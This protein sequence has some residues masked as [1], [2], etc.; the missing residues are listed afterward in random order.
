MGAKSIAACTN[1]AG[2]GFFG[3][4]AIFFVGL[5]GA[6]NGATVTTEAE[7]ALTC[8]TAATLSKLSC[9][10]KTNSRSDNTVVTSRKNA[11]GGN[12]T[13]TI[14]GATTGWVQD[15]T[16][17]DAL[18]AGDTF[19]VKVLMGAGSGNCI[20]DAFIAELDSS[21]NV[22]H[23]YFGIQRSSG[24]A[25]TASAASTTST[26]CAQGSAQSNTASGREKADLPATGTISNLQAYATANPR[27][28]ATTVQVNKA[29]AAGNNTVSVTASTT[30][31]FEDTTHSDAFTAGNALGFAVITGAG[32]GNLTFGRI[33]VMF[34]SADLTY[35]LFV[36][37]TGSVTKSSSGAYSIY[38]TGEMAI[39]NTNTEADAQMLAVH[40]MTW[41]NMQI[42]VGTVTTATFVVKSRVNGADGN[43]ALSLIAT[44]SGL[45]EDTTHS[46]ALVSGD[47]YNMRFDANTSVATLI[48][49][50][51]RMAG[52]AVQTAV[53]GGKSFFTG[54]AA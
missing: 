41:S 13:I 42:R 34:T 39:T 6:M 5:Y 22:A 37:E 9:Y 16:N 27:S 19:D 15:L 32:T 40:A 47:K 20:I 10:I 8:R 30:G 3:G 44:S 11:A 50:G 4:G 36:G 48:F 49:W 29:G 1:L 23:T 43:Q 14:A 2:G 24:A 51:S 53:E 33:S 52:P 12:M 28:T 25:F 26:I 54:I 7:V 45:F 31:L 35:P 46:D 18:V 38:A 21:A 17:S